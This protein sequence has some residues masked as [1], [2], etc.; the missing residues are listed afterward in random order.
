[1][2]MGVDDMHAD[3]VEGVHVEFGND[4]DGLILR[5]ELRLQHTTTQIIR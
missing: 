3:H 5:H 2:E 1:M 4:D